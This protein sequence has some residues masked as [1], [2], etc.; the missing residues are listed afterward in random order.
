MDVRIPDDD[1]NSTLDVAT[2]PE[3]NRKEEDRGGIE[4]GPIA[5]SLVRALV[6][7]RPDLAVGAEMV[8]SPKMSL[9]FLTMPS[10]ALPHETRME[11]LREKNAEAEFYVWCGIGL[12]LV[13]TA[14]GTFFSRG[15]Y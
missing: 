9:D 5:D 7:A 10:R 6:A 13:V 11:I 14:I 3:A 15:R 4:I 8:R 12:L 1:R 2:K